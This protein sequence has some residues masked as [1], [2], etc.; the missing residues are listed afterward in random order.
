SDFFNQGNRS[1]GK[2][3]VVTTTTER[4]TPDG[5]LLSTSHSRNIFFGDHQHHDIQ[6]DTV[7]CSTRR[8]RRQETPVIG[9]LLSQGRSPRVDEL[10]IREEMYRREDHS[11]HR[12]R[13]AS[14]VRHVPI[15][16]QYDNVHR[17]ETRTTFRE[18][19]NFRDEWRDER[20]DERRGER[21]EERDEEAV[22]IDPAQLC[23]NSTIYGDDWSER[24]SVC[25]QSHLVRQSDG[26][27]TELVLVLNRLNDL[28]LAR[29]LRALVVDCAL[30]QEAERLMREICIHGEMRSVDA[31][32]RLSL[33]K[34]DRL[35]AAIADL[36]THHGTTTTRSDRFDPTA[37][38]SLS[39]VGLASGYAHE[40]QKFVVVA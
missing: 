8:R 11:P 32:R 25:K 4:R 22:Y 15:S 26:L 31:S 23:G 39:V 33:W 10:M 1:R 7:V 29:R 36:W 38:S 3:T 35:H 17:A 30:M 40:E 12:P 27:S 6:H 14:R 21:R 9:P 5:R 24:G 20:R 28:R 2:Q 19:T 16:R 18:D 37:D 13:P 34:G